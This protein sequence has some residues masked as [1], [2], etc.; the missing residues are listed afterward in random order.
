MKRYLHILRLPLFASSDV[1]LSDQ[2]E[3][4]EFI[5]S[6]HGGD[7]TDILG[8]KYSHVSRLPLK[9]INLVL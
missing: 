4:I 9:L 1:S 7:G 2:S 3:L 5:L 6:I 8:R